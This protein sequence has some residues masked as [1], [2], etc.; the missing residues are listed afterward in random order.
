V[1]DILTAYIR[2][3]DPASLHRTPRGAALPVPTDIQ[4][5][6]TILATRDPSHDGLA[7]VNLEDTDLAH[8]SLEDANLVNANLQG[9]GPRPFQDRFSVRAGSPRLM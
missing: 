4:S 3:H 9:T 8:A 6:L 7:H 5:A 2:Y 1:I